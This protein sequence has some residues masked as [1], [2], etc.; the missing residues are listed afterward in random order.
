MSLVTIGT[1]AKSLVTSAMLS[2][3][4]FSSSV[5]TKS[6]YSVV[7][8]SFHISHAPLVPIEALLFADDS[9]MYFAD[10]GFVLCQL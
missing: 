9:P 6:L 1:Q 3:A 2:V 4:I 8:T 10:G 7:C 5:Q